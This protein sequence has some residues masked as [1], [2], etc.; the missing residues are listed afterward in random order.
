MPDQQ[1]AVLVLGGT[2]AND[3]DELFD[4]YELALL[5]S[6][7]AVGVFVATDEQMHFVQIGPTVVADCLGNGAVQTLTTAGG[8][9]F[10]FR[11][12]DPDLLINRMATLNVL[13]AGEL[14]ARSV[15]LLRGPVLISG[16]DPSGTP[17]GLSDGQIDRL[18]AEPQM[19]WWSERLLR[20]RVFLAQIRAHGN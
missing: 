9:V 5:W 19:S 1:P 2:V 12:R 15:P 14:A 4:P 16:F 13:V 20:I 10:W 17:S 7:S 18:K 6:R 11:A 8:I 3:Y